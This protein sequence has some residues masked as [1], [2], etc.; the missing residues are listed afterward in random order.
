MLE[1]SRELALNCQ[2]LRKDEESFYR[3]VNKIKKNKKI[4]EKKEAEI[5][6]VLEKKQQLNILTHL[7]SIKKLD[8]KIKNIEDSIPDI[9]DYI[10]KQQNKCAHLNGPNGLSKYIA[11]CEKLIKNHFY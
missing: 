1:L 4:L 11:E 8:K 3:A 9:I 5:L 6:K 7:K 2:F 10:Q